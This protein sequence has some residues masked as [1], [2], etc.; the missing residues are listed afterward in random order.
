MLRLLG[1][2]LERHFWSNDLRPRARL[3]RLPPRAPG[4]ACS[5]CAAAPAPRCSPAP[6]PP[7][8]R[9]RRRLEL[10]P[11]NAQALPRGSHGQHPRKA[12]RGIRWPKTRSHSSGYQRSLVAWGFKPLTL[13]MACWCDRQGTRN[14]MT[15]RKNRPTRGFL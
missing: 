15:P 6:S 4:A 11:E 13:Y 2:T 1:P 3:P 12:A 5:R 7:R 8:G 9:G 10:A 14:G